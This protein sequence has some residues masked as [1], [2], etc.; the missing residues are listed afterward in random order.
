[1]SLEYLSVEMERT[2][3]YNI[4]STTSYV[5]IVF[6][7]GSGFMHFRACKRLIKARNKYY[8]SRV[9]K[10]MTFVVKVVFHLVVVMYIIICENGH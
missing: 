8:T 7:S 2:F 10:A 5:V 1:M 3:I 9:I 6:D 4:C